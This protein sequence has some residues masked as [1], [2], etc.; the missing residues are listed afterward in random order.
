MPIINKIVPQSPVP[1]YLCSEYTWQYATLCIYNK[2]SVTMTHQPSMGWHGH[3]ASDFSSNKVNLPL[4]VFPEVA[5]VILSCQVFCA[6]YVSFIS[7]VRLCMF[8]SHPKLST[9]LMLSVGYYIEERVFNYL[10]K[11]INKII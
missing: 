7:A 3:I 10:N 11:N 8:V 9:L 1:L 4:D 5:V 6:M 2:V